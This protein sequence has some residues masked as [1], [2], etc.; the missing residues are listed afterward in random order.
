MPTSPCFSKL[1]RTE[2]CAICRQ[3]ISR[4]AVEVTTQATR[5]IAVFPREADAND[6][7]YAETK[8]KAHV[9]GDVIVQAQRVDQCSG[10]QL[11][12]HVPPDTID[13]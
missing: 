1:L 5:S 4:V 7:I 3:V 11:I 12:G 2:K 13:L 10:A 6:A 8:F 9:C